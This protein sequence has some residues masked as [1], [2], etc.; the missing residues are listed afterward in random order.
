M[1]PYN[2]WKSEYIILQQTELLG[3]RCPLPRVQRDRKTF[4]YFLLL[5]PKRLSKLHYHLLITARFCNTKRHRN[6]K[7]KKT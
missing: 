3:S 1:F 6:V 7:K 5:L 2:F 4:V